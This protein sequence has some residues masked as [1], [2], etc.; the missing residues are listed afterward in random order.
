MGEMGASVVG[1]GRVVVAREVKGRAGVVRGVVVVLVVVVVVVFRFLVGLR[2]LVVV[3]VDCVVVLVVLGV[4][5][6][7]VVVV[8]GRSGWCVM[9]LFGCGYETVSIV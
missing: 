1:G 9:V 5:D 3:V 7:V 8:C 6:V 4:V 2:R